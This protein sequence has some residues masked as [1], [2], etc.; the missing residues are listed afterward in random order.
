M[1]TWHLYNADKIYI[2]NSKYFNGL[3]IDKAFKIARYEQ[4]SFPQSL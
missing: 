2:L 3:Y 4:K 1:K